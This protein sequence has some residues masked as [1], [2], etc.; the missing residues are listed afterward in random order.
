MKGETIVVGAGI[1]GLTVATELGWA[2][3]IT[4]V[5][6]LPA[7]GG[8]LGYDHA[9][10]REA[11]ANALAAG[12]RLLLGTTA[13]RWE[14]RRLLVAGPQ[15][16]EWLEAGWLVVAAGARPAVAAEQRL[17]GSRLAGVFP[18]PVAIHLAEAGVHFGRRACVIG[19]TD[20]G[21]HATIALQRR[22]TRV[23]GISPDVTE[24]PGFGSEWWTG[25]TAT[26]VDGV[27]RVSTLAVTRDG[28]RAQIACDTVVL[29]DGIRPLRNVDGALAPSDA[30]SFVQ[31]ARGR[32][33]LGDVIE[34]ARAAAFTLKAAF[35]T[36][37]PAQGAVA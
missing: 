4:V 11:R 15:G 28:I 2:T 33:T 3:R 7:E 19:A 30:V 35:M 36:D 6:R 29:A 22:G 37:D 32:Q 27:G 25:W 9:E 8:V 13:L 24:V 23:I 17:A 1:A 31:P 10:V 16:I 18:A 5:D 34:Q 14:G 26:A 12:V 20:W 21:E